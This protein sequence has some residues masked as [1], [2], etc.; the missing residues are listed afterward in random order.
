M[1]Y[2]KVYITQEDVERAKTE[3][4]YHIACARQ[5]NQELICCLIE[6]TDER[7]RK[8][9]LTE[10]TKLLKKMKKENKLS[11]FLTSDAFH[12]ESVETEYLFNKHPDVKSDV[13]LNSTNTPYIFIRL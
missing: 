8:K 12:L 6:V 1:I 5:S 9:I 11:L 2:S 13:L 10:C 3:L 7:I 4:L